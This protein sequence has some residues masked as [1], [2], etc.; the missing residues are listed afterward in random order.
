MLVIFFI[1][2]AHYA[3]TPYMSKDSECGASHCTKGIM[4]RIEQDEVF[5]AAI[6]SRQA[7]S[8]EN[9][10]DEGFKFINKDW[11]HCVMKRG[12]F[13]PDYLIL[14]SNPARISSLGWH[15]ST[16]LADWYN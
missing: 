5:V 14:V 11:R 6:G 8:I 3:R 9:W 13:K 10:L 2:K 4:T 7:Y 16:T 12:N 1:T 15:V